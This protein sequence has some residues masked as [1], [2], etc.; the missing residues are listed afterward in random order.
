MG[1]KKTAASD[2]MYNPMIRLE[3]RYCVPAEKILEIREV[4]E[5]KEI[6]EH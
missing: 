2:Y 1:Y 5:W 4:N 3:D 6:F